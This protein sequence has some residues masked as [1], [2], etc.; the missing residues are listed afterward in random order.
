MAQ[1]LP[2]YTAGTVSIAAGGLTLTGAGTTWQTAGFREGDEFIANG[3]RMV[4]QSVN[5]N[6]SITLASNGGT[7]GGA[8]TNASY[9]L[10]YMSD[11]SRIGAQAQQL[12]AMLGDTGNLAA[13]G[14]LASAANTMPYFSGA[15]SAALTVLTAYARS[16]LAGADAAE[17][18]A[19]LGLLPVQANPLDLTANRLLRTGAFGLGAQRD[20]R[21]TIWESGNPTDLESRGEAFGL[22]NVAALGVP[23]LPTNQIGVLRVSTHWSR[24]AFTSF[25]REFK[26]LGRTFTQNGASETSWGPW[27]EI[28]TS[29][30]GVGKV[31][32]VYSLGNIANNAA[33]TLNI[34][35]TPRL[36]FAI[37]AN[38]QPRGGGGL[39]WG[40]SSGAPSL[41]VLAQSQTGG[42]TAIFSVAGGGTLDGTTGPSGSLNIRANTGG[43]LSIENRTGGTGTYGVIV[44]EGI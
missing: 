33:V 22:A 38:T 20:L 29:V 1:P 30:P 24:S 44:F 3:W 2:D 37:S 34:T 25:H 42:G 12:I 35:P 26:S 28:G 41:T 11:G 39:V 9:R 36:M 40:N 14:G 23:S 18:V 6:T 13:I 16:L 21:G 8:L 43:F 32:S 4:I 19:T 5:S 27:V 7:R 10:R 31:P 17:A 15:G